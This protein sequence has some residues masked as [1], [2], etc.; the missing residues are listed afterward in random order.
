MKNTSD[1]QPSSESIKP[2]SVW[3]ALLIGHLV[4]NSIVLIIILVGFG[5]GLAIIKLM[6]TLPQP[7]PDISF[8]FGMIS[9]GLGIAAGWLWWSFTVPRWRRW[10]LKSGAPKDELQTWGVLTGLVWPKGSIFEKTE[11]KIKE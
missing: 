3:K 10:A 6:E 4:I 7:F 9:V 8:L 11:F 2:I 1:P 5:V